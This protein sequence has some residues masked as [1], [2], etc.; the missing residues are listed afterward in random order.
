MACG[1]CATV[2]ERPRLTG[3]PADLKTCADEPEAPDL[4]AVDWSFLA[5][6]KAAQ[7]QRDM[8]TFNYVL[9][10]RASW[11]DCKA[12]VAGGAAWSATI[13]GK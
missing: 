9:G 3:L 7:A 10:L 8:M 2:K 6:A 12:K 11:G 1:A 5:T 13:E 4:P